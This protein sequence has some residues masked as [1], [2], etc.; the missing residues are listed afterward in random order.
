VKGRDA[1][2]R[3]FLI[4]GL[5][6]ILSLA[7]RALFA[8]FSRYA[9]QADAYFYFETARNIV[10]GQGY[11]LPDGR[12]LGSVSPVF[13]IFLAGVFKACGEGLTPALAAQV[14]VGSAT[15]VLVYYLA[16]LYFDRKVAVVGGAV[17]AIYPS[18]VWAA[19]VILTE[20]LTTLLLA[21]SLLTYY[22]A[23]RGSTAAAAL[24]GLLL[25]ATALCRSSFFAV[26]VVLIAGLL[27]CGERGR[28]IKLRAFGCAL[29]AFLVLIGGWAYRNYRVLGEPVPLTL[30][31]AQIFYEGN[32]KLAGEAA[33]HSVELRRSREF[34]ERVWAFRGTPR[35][36]LEYDR[37]Y[38][39]KAFAV[40][41]VN[42]LGFAVSLPGK[43][44]RYLRPAPDLES[45][46]YVPWTLVGG[47]VFVAAWAGILLYR[48]P[49]GRTFALL[50]PVIVNVAAHTIL[51]PLMRFRIPVEFLLIIYGAAFAVFCAG[52]VRRGRA[53][54][55]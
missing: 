36:D 2:V 44:V 46:L 39:E 48:S 7:P 10:S 13:P 32:Y 6:F 20:A 8:V 51:N 3:K 18:Y 34:R 4:P 11:V 50:S 23:T 1:I 15:V 28:T 25:A 35:L 9:L 16:K 52:R 37:Y 43:L 21:A 53:G 26:G 33:P 42:P 31:A 41:K 27:F 40:L 24:T 22:R 47:L 49:A 45:P 38:R 5:L 14:L 19:G 29:G 30:N 55:D 54:F 12:V 17:F